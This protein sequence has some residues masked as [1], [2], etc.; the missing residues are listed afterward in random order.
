MIDKQTRA[1]YIVKHRSGLNFDCRRFLQ[2]KEKIIVDNE[3]NLCYIKQAVARDSGCTLKIEQCKKAYANKHQ[4][5]IYL[6]E[7]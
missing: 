3:K 1:V 2:K 7:H 5:G 6:M 4:N